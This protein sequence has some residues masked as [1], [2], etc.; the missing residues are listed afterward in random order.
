[1]KRIIG[2]YKITYNNS[3]ISQLKNLVSKDDWDNVLKPIKNAI[4]IIEDDNKGRQNDQSKLLR[5]SLKLMFGDI[6]VCFKEGSP[7]YESIKSGFITLPYQQGGS[8]KV[9]WE[10]LKVC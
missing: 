2:S 9:T 3:G 10:K 5:E 4:S 1:M 7:M 8:H 6:D